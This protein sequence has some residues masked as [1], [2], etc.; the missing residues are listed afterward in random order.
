MIMTNV[1]KIDDKEINDT[2]LAWH[3]FNAHVYERVKSYITVCVKISLDGV[4]QD[5]I[6]KLK[7]SNYLEYGNAVLSLDSDVYLLVCISNEYA[8]FASYTDFKRNIAF[9]MSNVIIIAKELSTTI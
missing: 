4:Q 9:L 3:V 8:D 1:I 5:I 6:Q 2:K 7:Q